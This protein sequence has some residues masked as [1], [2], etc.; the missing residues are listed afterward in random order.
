MAEVIP[1]RS[2]FIAS[3]TYYHNDEGDRQAEDLVIEFTD[4]AEFVYE[5]VP[6]GTYTAFIT[7]PSRGKAFHQII[8]DRFP[9]EEL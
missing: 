4:G 5:G 8:K 6:R 1:Q 2:S 7:A 9:G 3:T